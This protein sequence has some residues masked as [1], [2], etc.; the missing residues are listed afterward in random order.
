MRR[1][2]RRS[3]AARILGFLAAVGQRF[4]AD[5]CLVRASA[6]AYVSLLSMVPLLAVMF[7]VLK[8]LGVQQE[9][10]SVLLSR[11]SLSGEASATIVGFVDRIN[12]GT[13]GGLGAAM[14]LVTVI[15]VL[16]GIESSLNHI[17][18]VRRDRSPWRKVTDYLGVVLL[19][20]FLLLAAVALTSSMQVERV[21]DW[22][23]ASPYLGTA[24]VQ[25]L[26][27]VPVA[28]NVLAIGLLYTVMPNRR[29]AP[30]AVAVG[31]L[32]A[33]VSWHL[34][35][36][37]Y[38]HFQIGVANYGAIYGALSQLPITLVWLYVSWA[39]VLLGAEIAAVTEF[40]WQHLDSEPSAPSAAAVALHL[41]VT[42]ADRFHDGEPGIDLAASAR[43]LGVD[44]DTVVAAAAALERLGWVAAVEEE[45]PRLL[46][47]RDPAALSLGALAELAPRQLP[48][49]GCDARVRAALSRF[50]KD[51]RAAW[52]ARTVADVLAGG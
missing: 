32:V 4:Y 17:W 41:V 7:A 6:L 30:V 37:A 25:A 34:V 44:L 2:G 27:L 10:E 21:L 35:Q 46:L 20:P 52:E 36:V 39:V 9:L 5:Q 13:L 8:G 18:R 11:L 47:A 49:S 33:G 40:G 31:A 43:E 12:V 29:A 24:A 22:M 1:G 51:E 23:L 28:I 48:P 16:G 19:T 45:P 14:L 50:E 38:I 15:S 3:I 26:R 42:A